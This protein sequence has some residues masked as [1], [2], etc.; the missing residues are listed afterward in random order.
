MEII[1]EQESGKYIVMHTR[2]ALSRREREIEGPE[3]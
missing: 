2:F 1:K 3:L